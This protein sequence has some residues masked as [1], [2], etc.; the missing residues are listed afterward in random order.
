MFKVNLFGAGRAEYA[1]KQLVGF[2]AQQPYLLLCYIL[3]HPDTAHHREQLAT[4]FWGDYPTHLAKKYFRNALWR[5]RTLL[6][7]CGMPVDDYLVVQDEWISFGTASPCW[8]DVDVIKTVSARYGH[9][10]PPELIPD[11]AA[12]LRQAAEVF[13]GELLEGVYEDWAIFE[14][15]RLRLQGLN[16]LSQLVEYHAAQADFEHGLEYCT[17]IL[18]HENTREDIHRQMMWMYWQSGNPASALNQYKLCCQVLREEMGVAPTEATR[19]LYQQMLQHPRNPPPLNESLYPNQTAGSPGLQTMIASVFEKLLD[20][21]KMMTSTNSEIQQIKGLF[22]VMSGGEGD[23]KANNQG[24]KR[25][26]QKAG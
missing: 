25:E 17:R 11:Q 23:H 26:N 24:L 2:P 14:R 4:A 6:S 21:E 18:A 19:M 20:L 3:L 13:S 22:Q 15:E 1:G 7:D 16:L 12:E 9:V 8:V 5:L 10:P